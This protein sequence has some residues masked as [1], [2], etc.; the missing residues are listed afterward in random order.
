MDRDG[1]SFSLGIT[2]RDAP[3]YAADRNSYGKISQTD[4]TW[5]AIRYICGGVNELASSLIKV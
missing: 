2:D 4:I 3:N 5:N 1:G